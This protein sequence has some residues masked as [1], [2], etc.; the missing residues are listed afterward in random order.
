MIVVLAL[1]ASILEQRLS[2]MKAR[3]VGTSPTMT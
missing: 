2:S 3:L 1:V